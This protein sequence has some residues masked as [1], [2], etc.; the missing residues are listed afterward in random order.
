ME[1]LKKMKL[2][3]LVVLFTIFFTVNIKAQNKTQY[4]GWS[5][6]NITGS[7]YKFTDKSYT[8]I[9]MSENVRLM[10]DNQLTEKILFEIDFDL[11]FNHQNNQL[12]INQSD[13]GFS[14]RAFDFNNYWDIDEGPKRRTALFYSLDR[15]FFTY[16]ADS[17]DFIFGRQP[18][19]FGSSR[20]VNPTDVVIP[21]PIVAIDKEERSGVD[22]LRIKKPIGDMGEL[23]VG[24]IFGNDLKSIN[25]AAFINLRLPIFNIDFS[26]MIMK[27]KENLMVG[28]DLQGALLGAGWWSELSHVIPNVST[29][30]YFRATFGMDYKFTENLYLFSELYFNGAGVSSSNFYLTRLTHSA[31]TQGGVSLFGRQYLSLGLSYQVSPLISLSKSFMFNYLDS[32]VL[33]FIKIEW[34]VYAGHYFDLGSI[35][36]IGKY[37]DSVNDIRSEFGQFGKQYYLNYR[38]YF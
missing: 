31:Y 7:V 27:F 24:F 11:S 19:S 23:D 30:N 12:Q 32:S 34:N 20:F 10:I 18:I 37:G 6:T 14:Y 38:Y 3:N 1:G 9:V 22:A 26:A 29:E 33:S 5:K 16:S 25:S 36:G 28:L 2:F 17:Y 4:I 15:V 35:M 13:V 21:F 8:N